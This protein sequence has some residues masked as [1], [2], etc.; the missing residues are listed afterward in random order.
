[1]KYS[2][3]QIRQAVKLVA[4][5]CQAHSKN[6]ECNGADTK[7]GADKRCPFCH[8]VEINPYTGKIERWLCCFG[9]CEAWPAPAYNYYKDTADREFVY[10]DGAPWQGEK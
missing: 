1:M 10:G 3:K 5:I 9:E 2:E 7:G 8:I 4:D 6:G